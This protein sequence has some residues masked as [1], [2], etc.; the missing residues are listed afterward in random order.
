MGRSQ[1]QNEVVVCFQHAAIATNATSASTVDT[2][3]QAGPASLYVFMAPST[4][5]SSNAKWTSLVIQHGT[6]T[7]VSNFTAIAGMTGT[8]ESTAT[9]DQFVIQ[10][11]NDSTNAAAHIFDLDLSTLER[12]LRVVKEAPASHAETSNL[13][14]FKRP[15]NTPS[16]ASERGP[17]SGTMTVVQKMTGDTA[18]TLS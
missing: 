11:H 5:T 3:G 6:T 2:L 9:T 17:D 14:I 12:H 8:T 1:I 16:Q 15:L 4:N 7:D 18:T 13:L 10:T